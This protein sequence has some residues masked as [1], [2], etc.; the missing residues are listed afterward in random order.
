MPGELLPTNRC[1]S[2]SAPLC[3]HCSPRPTASSTSSA[4]SPS[5]SSSPAAPWTPPSS[6][7]RWPGW[8]ASCRTWRG[9]GAC[10]AAA[11]SST[12]SCLPATRASSWRWRLRPASG[13]AE[14]GLSALKVVQVSFNSGSQ[15]VP[16]RCP[17]TTHRSQPGVGGPAHL[18]VHQRRP[19]ARRLPPAFLRPAP[20]RH[21]GGGWRGAAAAPA[22]SGRVASGSWRRLPCCRTHAHLNPTATC[23]S[24]VLSSLTA[25]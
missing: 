9:A 5:P 7:P 12:K 1:P 8:R 23:L 3:I 18:G 19:P 25:G 14:V 13:A 2:R 6:R 17:P 16:A 24:T 22:V 10:W 21:G 20:Q 4:P 11:A 15:H